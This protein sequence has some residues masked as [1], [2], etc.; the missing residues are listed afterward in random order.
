LSDD[1]AEFLQVE[2][3]EPCGQSMFATVCENLQRIQFGWRSASGALEP[4]WHFNQ[5]HKLR[6]GM[7]SP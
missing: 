6:V 2:T 3:C 1:V 5:I 4:R 7:K